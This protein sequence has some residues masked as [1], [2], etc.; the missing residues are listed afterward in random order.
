VV[1]SKQRILEENERSRK[2][3]DGA[4]RLGFFLIYPTPPNS[5]VPRDECKNCK[6][7]D[8]VLKY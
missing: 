5:Q 7:V 2:A 8:D 4:D 3:Q 1:V 6:F